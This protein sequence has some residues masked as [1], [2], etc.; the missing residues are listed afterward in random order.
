MAG[1]VWGWNSPPGATWEALN[2]GWGANSGGPSWNADCGEVEA[3]GGEEV[4]GGKTLPGST[5]TELC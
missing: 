3:T 1:E 5:S 2:M 4:C